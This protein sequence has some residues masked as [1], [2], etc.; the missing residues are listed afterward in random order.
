MEF[1]L[2]VIKIS[3]YRA[4]NFSV[5]HKTNQKSKAFIFLTKISKC[6]FILI[7]LNEF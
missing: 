4:K 2:T 1:S 3:S 6:A 7:F 5:L